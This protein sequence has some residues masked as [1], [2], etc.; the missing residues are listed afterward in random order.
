MMNAGKQ[1]GGIQRKN[2]VGYVEESVRI[3]GREVVTI[4]HK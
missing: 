1:L 3:N 2:S 4:V